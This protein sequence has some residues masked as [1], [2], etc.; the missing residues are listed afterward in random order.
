MT[1]F[2]A[3]KNIP[4]D[5]Q[6]PAVCTAYRETREETSVEVVVGNLISN[7]DSFAAF[8]CLALDP[9]ALLK[10]LQSEDPA[11]VEKIG[12]FTLEE[13]KAPG[14]LRFDSNLPIAEAASESLID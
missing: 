9:K 13:M 11:E 3:A 6:E 1:T 12:W 8:F 5:Y 2:E 14:F 4:F 10:P 7:S